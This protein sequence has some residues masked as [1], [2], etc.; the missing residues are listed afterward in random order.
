MKV[1]FITPLFDPWNIGGAEKYIN[2]L[3]NFF[4]KNHNVVVIT[5]Q[6]PLKRDLK[7]TN[8][9]FKIIELKSSNIISY[10][11]ILKND[12]DINSVR[13]FFWNVLDLWNISHYYQIQKILETE[14]PDIVHINGITG[15]SSSVFSA[16]KKL[17]IPHVLTLHDYELISRWSTLFRN[18]KPITEFN[19]LEKIYIKFMKHFSSSISGVIS[20]SQFVMDYHTKLGFFEKS[21]KHVIPHGTEFNTR[22]TP[23]E[24]MKKEFIF[25]G[26]LTQQKGPHIAIHAIKKVNDNDLKLHVVG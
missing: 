17:K 12:Q 19:M 18:G 9:N 11:S 3:V 2:I 20:P 16:L 24:R 23:K 8:S 10:Y 4:S 1:C 25:L 15:L 7:K 5:T 21:C 14:K 22:A 13:K 26:R 6:G